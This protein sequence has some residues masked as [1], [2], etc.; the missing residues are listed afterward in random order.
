MERVYTLE[1]VKICGQVTLE[2]LGLTQE[3]QIRNE[4]ISEMFKILI[5]SP[6]ALNIPSYYFQ[7]D[8]ISVG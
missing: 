3:N 2:S 6:P 7:I 4:L 8:S 1:T 5:V